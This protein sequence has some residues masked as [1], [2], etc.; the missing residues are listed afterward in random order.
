MSPVEMASSFDRFHGELLRPGDAHYDEAR[1]IHNG[2]IDKH[3]SLIARCR[4][5]ADIVSAVNVA[6]DT[7]I[8]L[9][10]RGGGH[11]VAGRAV[12]EGGLM[13]D[14]SGMRAVEVDHGART[15]R[16]QEARRGAS[17]TAKRSSGG[18]R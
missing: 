4:T 16:A 17:S 13:L 11:N 3:P 18:W 8:E 2:L 12:T 9:S 10:V 1:R 6:R 14:L 15:A 7:G 5:T